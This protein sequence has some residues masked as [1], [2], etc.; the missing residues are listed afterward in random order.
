M[1]GNET[2]RLRELEEKL[3]RLEE[4]QAKDHSKLM[5]MMLSFIRP[6][7]AVS[8][9]TLQSGI[10]SSDAALEQ[11]AKDGKEEKSDRELIESWAGLRPDDER[12]SDPTP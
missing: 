4:Q 12:T 8:A 9:A 10:L 2:K 1:N 6:L 5:G 11:V 7:I 3:A